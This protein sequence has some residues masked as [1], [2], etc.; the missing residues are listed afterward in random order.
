MV[1]PGRMAGPPLVPNRATAFDMSVVLFARMFGYLTLRMAPI[2]SVF[3]MAL[4]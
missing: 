4:G 3:L 2:Q 1:E